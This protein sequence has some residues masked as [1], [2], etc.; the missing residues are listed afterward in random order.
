MAGVQPE[1]CSKGYGGELDGVQI[2]NV[3][4]EIDLIADELV[5]L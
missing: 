4:S 1:M 2:W 3:G 5:S